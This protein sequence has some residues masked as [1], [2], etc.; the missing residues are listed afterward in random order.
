MKTRIIA[1]AAA[2]VIFGLSA[3]TKCETCTAAYT[4]GSPSPHSQSMYLCSKAYINSYETGK[5]TDPQGKT[6]IWTCK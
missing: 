2:T 6:V 3:C 1:I 4:N 5:H